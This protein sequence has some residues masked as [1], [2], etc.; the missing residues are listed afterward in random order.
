MIKILVTGG[1]GFIGSALLPLLLENDFQVRILDLCI[2]G[3]EAIKP[4]LDHP[5]LEII[6]ADFRKTD[7]VDQAMQ[8]VEAV[9]HLGAIVADAACDLDEKLAIEVNQQATQIIAE[10]AQR[11]GVDR[12]IFASSC[13]V[14]GASEWLLDETSPLKPVSLYSSTKAASESILF[15]MAS[16]QFSPVILRFSTLYGQSGRYRF[17]LVVNLLS[18]KALVDGVITVHGGNQWRAFVHVQDVARA[19]LQVLTSPIQAVRGQVYNVGSNGQNYTISQI[20]EIIHGHVPLAHILVDDQPD[21]NNYR[22]D[23]SKIQKQLNFSPRW[24]INQGVEQV[25]TAIQDG[26][27][28][29]YRDPR[30]NNAL[31][32]STGGLDLLRHLEKSPAT[33]P[34]EL[35]S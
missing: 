15:S 23:F 6:Q 12:F 33:L 9:V 19:I 24:S 31:Y 22:V 32:L 5:Q 35:D 13:S 29:N 17:D 30:F 25:I 20:G 27:I 34:H 10:T 18:A 21:A 26:R 11:K 28:A 14:Y 1:A 3:T 2:Y 7:V 4:Y 8:D 16:N